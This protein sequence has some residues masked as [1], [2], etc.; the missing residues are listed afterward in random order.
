LKKQ[1]LMVR[2]AD[3]VV[4][5][6]MLQDD[7]DVGPLR[8]PPQPAPEGVR[9]VP[10]AGEFSR[11]GRPETAIARHIDEAI[12]WE[13]GA[14][15]GPLLLEALDAIDTLAEDARASALIKK[16]K[17][18]EYTQAEAQ[19][20]EWQAAGFVGEAPE[21]VQSWAD[22]KWRDGMTPLQAAHGILAQAAQYQGLLSAIR[23]L[24]LKYMEDARHAADVPDL[25]AVV[26]AF[27]AKLN[28]T[29]GVNG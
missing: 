19:A 15:L 27:T 18:L 7:P 25:R 9:L 5:G 8:K 21:D 13:E 12:V 11:D 3:D 6:C 1:F 16:T 23:R 24:R 2:E 29:M 14:Q 4:L 22:A 17:S 28:T 20:K 26:E 10:F